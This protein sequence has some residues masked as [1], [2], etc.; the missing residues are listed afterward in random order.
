[1]RWFF[2]VL[3]FVTSLSKDCCVPNDN[4]SQFK[5]CGK[6]KTMNDC[7]GTS[8]GAANCKWDWSACY[9]KEKD[10]RG[11][12]KEEMKADWTGT[13]TK[14]KIDDKYKSGDA[15]VG[16]AIPQKMD[17]EEYFGEYHMMTV[18]YIY[19]YDMIYLSMLI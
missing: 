16:E 7:I 13:Y 15:L 11:D 18:K 3:L 12:S 14:G 5:G 10:L 8:K 1:M 4:E 17:K 2:F 6:L 19:I 9:F